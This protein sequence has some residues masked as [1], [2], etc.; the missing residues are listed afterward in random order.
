MREERVEI[1]YVRR[2]CCC[3]DVV[4][5]GR[6]FAESRGVVAEDDAPWD[7][8]NAVALVPHSRALKAASTRPTLECST[9]NV[10][11]ASAA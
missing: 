1:L 8:R 10:N 9:A 4:R 2:H 7:G 6:R 5:M 11:Q 3:Y